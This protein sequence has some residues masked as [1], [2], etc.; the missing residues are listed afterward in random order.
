L[1]DEQAEY[2]FWNWRW[3]G[4]FVLMAADIELAVKVGLRKSYQ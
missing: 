1:W 4:A 2:R 3:H